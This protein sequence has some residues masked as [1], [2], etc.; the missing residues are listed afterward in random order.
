MPAQFPTLTEVRHA[1][2]HTEVLPLT[3]VQIDVVRCRLQ[4]LNHRRCAI[5]R[6]RAD[7]LLTMSAVFA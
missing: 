1:S 5:D 2:L 3:A 4:K 7:E 6:Q